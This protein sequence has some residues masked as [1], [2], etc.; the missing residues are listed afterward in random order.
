MKRAG[1][2]IHW[3]YCKSKCPYCDFFSRVAKVDQDELIKSYLDDLIYYRNLNNNYHISTIFFGGGTPSLISPQNIEKIIDKIT[4]LWHCSENMEISL[5]AN[6]NTNHDNLFSDLKQAGINRLSLGVQSLNKNDLKFLG[7][8]HSLEQA[9]SSIEQVVKTFDNNSMDLIY[10]LPYQTAR[11]WKQQ[12]E[13][14]CQFGFKHLSLY[15]LTIEENTVFAKRGINGAS[16]EVCQELYSLSEDVLSSHGYNRYEVS[17]YAQSGFECRHNLGYWEGF[18]Y[19][20][21]GNGAVGRF[22]I[23]KNIYNTFYPRQQE[24]ITPHERAEELLIMGLR[25][26]KGINKKL[27]RK[28]CGSELD[29]CTNQ[30]N[31]QKL[32]RSGLI[33]NTETSLKTTAKGNFLL[34]YLIENL[35]K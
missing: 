34:N 24:L 3:P 14:A 12:L 10:A 17:N 18:D 2:Y 22:H 20:G 7:R 33:T 30:E 19:I 35:V 23:G 11:D 1:I 29:E 8:T 5:E 21:I 15:Q 6:P 27:F 16:D 31:L 4:S 25:L 26:K 28:N 32:I 13:Q 9:V